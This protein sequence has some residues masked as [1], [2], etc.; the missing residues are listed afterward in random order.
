MGPDIK[1]C[2]VV[3]GGPAGLTAALYLARFL[4]SVLVFDAQHG[5]AR[6]IPR[7][8][9]LAAFPNGISGQELLSRMQRHAEKYGAMIENNTVTLVENQ[10]E[11]FQVTTDEKT[12]LTRT[13]ILASGVF[14]HRP[15]LPVAEHDGGL[16]RGLIRYCPVCD[17]H[18]IRGKRISVLG[19]GQHGFAEARFIL[20]YSPFVTLIPPDGS[21]EVAKD[22]IAVLDAPMTNLALSR[23]EVFVTLQ[24]GSVRQFDTMYVALGTTPQTHLATGLGVKLDAAGYVKVDAKQQTNVPRV[25]AVGDIIDGLDQIVVG[26]GQA[27]TAASAIHND[28]R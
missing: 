18:E 19:S 23:S 13:V 3:G 7:T 4:R 2:V 17:A 9:N 27:A 8:H 26:M 6:M 28:L 24:N 10:G 22:G 1:D 5:R 14:N 20:P 16:A 21:I 11:V 15:P 12:I 25:F